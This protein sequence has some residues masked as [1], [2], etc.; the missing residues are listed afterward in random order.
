[1]I[2]ID[3]IWVCLYWKRGKSAQGRVGLGERAEF[4]TY[5]EN[6][7]SFENERVKDEASALPRPKFTLWFDRFSSAFPLESH[8][9]LLQTAVGVSVAK[10]EVD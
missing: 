1:M 8:P 2:I 6:I 10:E 7:L 5:P 3:L 4:T 9:F